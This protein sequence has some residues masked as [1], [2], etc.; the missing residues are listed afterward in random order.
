ML[1]S[2]LFAALT[3]L[4]L[5]GETKKNVYIYFKS[6]EN[7]KYYYLLGKDTFYNEIFGTKYA[8]ILTNTL[9]DLK[10]AAYIVTEE[11]PLYD[12]Q[13][14]FLAH[15]PKNKVL[16]FS[17]E[18]PLTQTRSQQKEYHQYYSKIFTWCDDLIDSI[19]YFKVRYPWTDPLPM[20]TNRLEFE[21]KKLCVFVARY[22]YIEAPCSNHPERMHMIEFFEKNY[23]NY[24][25]LY[26]P[27][28]QVFHYSCYKGIIPLGQTN[29]IS[30]MNKINVIKN[31]K[32]DMCYENA[33]GLNGYV[34]ER[35]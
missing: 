23:P 28:W 22:N 21:A 19:K 7:K 29:K 17:F 2:L 25:D 14:A 30:R 13:Y 33:Q 3:T 35:I 24:F 26:G 10:D 6:N 27:S 31:Y 32:F 4:S 18:A 9:K 8:V 16:L 20:I 5:S 1:I 15:Y 12:L 11:V 34:T